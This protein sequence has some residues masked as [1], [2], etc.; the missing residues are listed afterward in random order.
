MMVTTIAP[1][2]VALSTQP[3]LAPVFPLP[4][5]V[6]CEIPSERDTAADAASRNMSLL[7][8]ACHIKV[9]KD[10]AFAWGRRFLPK[11]RRRSKKAAG[12]RFFG[13]RRAWN[14]GRGGG[15]VDTSDGLLEKAY[16]SVSSALIPVLGSVRSPLQSPCRPPMASIP[17]FL[18]SLRS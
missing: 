12:G 16:S 1:M 8:K 9:K 3:T 14:D 18:L 6:I 5:M 7:L 4:V 13:A 15:F 17:D 10:V 11:T 2:M